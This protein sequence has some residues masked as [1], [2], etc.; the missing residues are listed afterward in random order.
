MIESFSNIN[1]IYGVRSE[2]IINDVT[3]KDAIDSGLDLVS[4]IVSTGCSAPGAILED[5]SNEF[6]D[7]YNKSDIIISK[8]QGNYEALSE[9]KGNIFFLLKAKSPM[10]S[11]KLNVN[12]NEYIFK[13]GGIKQS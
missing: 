1:I 10:I 6:I 8:G 3:E 5:C 11:K 7:I 9:E 13:F 2:P 4:K 12:L